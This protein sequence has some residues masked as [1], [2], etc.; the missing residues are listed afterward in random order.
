MK[1][2]SSVGATESEN[3]PVNSAKFKLVYS[4]FDLLSSYFNFNFSYILFVK[5]V[6]L[7]SE[8][9]VDTGLEPETL[10]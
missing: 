9:S 2:L 3:V 7:S 8:I 1:E 4:D 10:G 5:L 6:I